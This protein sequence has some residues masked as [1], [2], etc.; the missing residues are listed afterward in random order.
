MNHNHTV[1]WL[2]E[3]RMPVSQAL[4]GYMVYVNQAD[5]TYYGMRYI[6]KGTTSASWSMPPGDYIEYVSASNADGSIQE[7]QIQRPFTVGDPVVIDPPPN[8]EPGMFPFPVWGDPYVPPVIAPGAPDK[9]IWEIN[10]ETYGRRHGEYILTHPNDTVDQKLGFVYYDMC[11][12]MANIA[13]YTGEAEPWHTYAKESMKWFRDTYVIPNNAGVP[14]YEN[15]TTGLRMDYERT[16]DALSKEWAIK[17]SQNAAFASDLTDRAY[18]AKHGTSREVAYAIISYI[19]AEALGEAKRPIR[20]E[21]VTLSHD[22]IDQWMAEAWQGGP[23][24][25]SPFMMAITAQALILDWEETQDDRC[26]PAL[27][28]LADWMWPLSWDEGRSALRYQINPTSTEGYTTDGAPDLN[29]I[30]APW[31]AWLWVQTGDV[32]YREWF[33]KLLYGSQNAWLDGGK[34]FDQNYWW[35]F[36]GMRWREEGLNP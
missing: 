8:P 34:Q 21:W 1:Q 15:F 3:N 5:G 13:A 28:V 2:T 36:E 35:A 20:A 11:R 33:D 25:I 10:M 17:L 12:V 19:N 27:Q 6:P 18:V 9:E 26:L 4:T 16:G 7:G 29:M 23:D 30:S 32:K 24:Q 22:Y 31:M 14:G